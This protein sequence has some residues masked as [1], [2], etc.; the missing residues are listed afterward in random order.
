[1]IKEIVDSKIKRFKARLV[2]RGFSQSYSIDYTKTF[3]L[4]I[5]ID[6]LCLF[7]VI[8]VKRDLE[9]SY[10]DIKNAFTKSHL[11]ED[12][13]LALPKG[14]TIIVRKVLKVLR[15]LYSLKQVGRD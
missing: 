2:V 15:S 14:V 3:A 10:F 4:T 8:V 11:K 1:M 7:L 12:I 5:R 13:F 9:Y 6:T